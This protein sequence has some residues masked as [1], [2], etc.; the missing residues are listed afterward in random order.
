ML[1]ALQ[2]FQVNGEAAVLKAMTSLC[3]G[4]HRHTTFRAISESMV[5]SIERL[6]SSLVFCHVKHTLSLDLPIPCKT[7][8]D[9]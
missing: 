9:V 2:C 5:M 8:G 3:K 1:P 7:K 4:E 6:H